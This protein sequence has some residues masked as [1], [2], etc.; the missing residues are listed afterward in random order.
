MALSNISL[1]IR[2]A[3]A[4]GK[5]GCRPGVAVTGGDARG[6]HVLQLGPLPGPGE[7]E[8]QL[9]WSKLPL[10]AAPVL[11]LPQRLRRPRPEHSP[12]PHETSAAAPAA[13]DGAGC[14]PCRGDRPHAPG[15]R[16]EEQSWLLPACSSKR[17]QTPRQTW[18][19]AGSSCQ[20]P[21]PAPACGQSRGC[22]CSPPQAPGHGGGTVGCARGQPPHQPCLGFPAAARL[23]G[24]RSGVQRGGMEL[25]LLSRR[26][27]PWGGGP[28][29]GISYFEPVTDKRGRRVT[30]KGSRLCS[31]H[32]VPL[33]R[34][35]RGIP[36]PTGMGGSCRLHGHAERALA[37]GCWH[38]A[39][40]RELRVM[41]GCAQNPSDCGKAK[42]W[43]CHTGSGSTTQPLRTRV[44]GAWG[45]GGCSAHPPFPSPSQGAGRAGC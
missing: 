7:G 24:L 20:Q 41:P 43:G 22:G 27:L 5:R 37:P 29:R 38:L 15:C 32:C 2:D 12:A 25:A 36:S 10:A 23:T 17:G 44:R 11:A 42:P 35:G 21:V 14:P 16:G 3:W 13:A 39:P 19:Q 18:G 28:L 8:A 1:W 4:G 9:P 45:T 6:G 30:A 26:H 33:L 40:S 31:G 34:L